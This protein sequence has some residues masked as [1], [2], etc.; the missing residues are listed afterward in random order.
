[1]LLIEKIIQHA[2]IAISFLIAIPGVGTPDLGT[3]LDISH[4]VIGI[5]NAILA[6]LFGCVIWGIAADKNWSKTLILFL[7]V[8]D[9]AAEFIFHGFF[10]ITFSVLGAAI[11]IILL[12]IYPTGKKLGTLSP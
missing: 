5:S 12:L 9:I 10:F 7:A 3:R 1:V 8:I 6:A 4:P 11:L 2:L